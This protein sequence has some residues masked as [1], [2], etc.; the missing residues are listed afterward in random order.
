VQSRVR[1][2]AVVGLCL[3]NSYGQF[4]RHLKSHSFRINESQ[5]IVTLIF[6]TIQKNTYLPTCYLVCRLQFIA[7]LSFQR[8][9]FQCLSTEVLPILRH[10][11]AYAT[12][13]PTDP[14]SPNYSKINETQNPDLQYFVN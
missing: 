8:H 4:R 12:K 11:V 10:D 5:R 1:T 14:I 7:I 2:F 9:I 6:C 13:S 3:A